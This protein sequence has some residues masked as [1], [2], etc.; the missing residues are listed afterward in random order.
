MAKKYEKEGDA[1]PECKVGHFHYGKVQRCY[2]HTSPPCSAC[3]D[4]PL[5]CDECGHEAEL[6]PEKV[7]TEEERL[8]WAKYSEEEGRKRDERRKQGHTFPHGGRIFDVDWD[9]SSGSTMEYRGKYEGPV[10]AADI[11]E[12]LGYGTF[13]HR[14]PSLWNG[15]FAYTKITD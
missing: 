3:V 2:C 13:G 14:G 4:N 12:H 5:V 11:L 7:Q 15:S 6:E 1:C 10:T 8:F 9:G